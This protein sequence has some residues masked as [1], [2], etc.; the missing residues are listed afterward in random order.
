MHDRRAPQEPQP[1]RPAEPN[2]REVK[3]AE[4][5]FTLVEIAVSMIILVFGLLALAQAMILAYRMERTSEERKIALRWMTSHVENVRSLGYQSV[6]DNAPSGYG[7]PWSDGALL[8]YQK[9]LDS[10]GDTDLRVRQYYSLATTAAYSGSGGTIPLYDA[11]LQGLQPQ[12]GSSD[13][14]GTV[15]IRDCD[16]STGVA[17]GKGYWITVRVAWKGSAGPSEMMMST[18]VVLR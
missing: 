2:S 1:I 9:D 7:V 5:G 10:D 8:G 4:G 3:R 11:L 12:D 16:N 6:D 18:L 15:T 14:V 13:V 17:E